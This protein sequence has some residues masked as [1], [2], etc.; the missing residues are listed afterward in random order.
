M[1]F[2]PI[3]R[4]IAAALASVT[5]TAWRAAASDPARTVGK[6]LPLGALLTGMTLATD[7]AFAQTPPG[8][9]PGETTLPTVDVRDMRETGYRGGVTEVGKLPQAPRDIPQSLT[10]IPE[11]LIR[12]R[13]AATLQDALQN[14][15]GITFA[16]GEGG[17]IGDNFWLRG[18]P[19]YGDLYL[20]GIRDV[21][22]Y[23]RDTF[24]VEQIDILRGPSSM[25]FGRGSTGG[26]ANQVSKQPYIL[27]QYEA[28]L[29]YGS[30]DYKRATADLNKVIGENSALRLNAMWHDADSFRGEGPQFGR[31]G[32]APALRWGI[33]TK[34]EIALSYYY[35]KVDNVP[36]FGV[37]YFQGQPLDVPVDRFYGFANG[38]YERYETGI[39]TGSLLY[40]FTPDTWIRTALRRGDYSRDLWS[41]VPRLVPGTTVIT[42]N[43]LINRQRQARGGDEQNLVSQTDFVS[44]FRALGMKHQVLAGLELLR[45]EAERWSYAPTGTIPQVRV[46][47]PDPYPVLPLGFFNK[48]RTNEVNFESNTVGI[49]AQDM[50]EFVPHWTLLLGGRWDRMDA[51]YQRAAPLGPLDRVDSVFS[52]RTGLIWQPT[53]AQ[54]YYAAYGTSFNPSAELYSLD[55]RGTNTPPEESR[56]MEIGAKWDLFSNNLSLRTALFRTEK[57]NERNTDPLVADQYLLSGRRHTQGIELEGAGRITREWEVFGGVVWQK[58]RVDESIIPNEVGKWPLNTPPYT[59]NLWTTYRLPHGWRVG[60]GFYA[61]GKRYGQ[62]ANTTSGPSYVRWDAMLAYEQ[63]EY[64]VRL[65]LFN[66]FDTRY[67]DTVYQGHIIPGTS[68]V[69]QATLELK[70]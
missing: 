56:N 11:Q 13:G 18:F 2:R 53:D 21:A 64:A 55:P 26:V 3:L 1:A 59:A 23:T 24:N 8:T 57:T 51:E 33:G 19:I 16:A 69:I 60:G 35:L 66:L 12:D 63:R 47:F 14:A 48:T 42:D 4:P 45:E 9:A 25:L 44:T 37:P 46:G 31:W 30:Y 5:P 67:Y 6:V 36:D 39:A 7:P 50:I 20:D 52:Y 65:N 28:S 62:N 15:V 58:A 43:T 54:S 22:Q 32:V 27:D 29:T 34:T 41:S 49:Y 68:R 40:R 70:Y 61:A 17:R 10:I 38:A